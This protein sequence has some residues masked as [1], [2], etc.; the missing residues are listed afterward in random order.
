MM[1]VSAFHAH[2]QVFP[3]DEPLYKLNV[4]PGSCYTQMLLQLLYRRMARAHHGD[5]G[6]A[7]NKAEFSTQQET[8]RAVAPWKHME[9]LWIR[10]LRHR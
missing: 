6:S 2:G 1:C 9:K 10:C 7:G 4:I 3:E 8:K 5:T